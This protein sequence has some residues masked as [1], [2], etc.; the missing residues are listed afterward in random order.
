MSAILNLLPE[1]LLS[2]A[3]VILPAKV[4]SPPTSK[5]KSPAPAFNNL[6]IKSVPTFEPI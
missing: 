4:A 1:L 3:A 6:N 2:K 5:L